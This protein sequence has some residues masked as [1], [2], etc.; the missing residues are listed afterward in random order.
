M[1]YACLLAGDGSF[2]FSFSLF[3]GSTVPAVIKASIM[4]FLNKQVPLGVFPRSCDIFCFLLLCLNPV[5]PS[6]F[7]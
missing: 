3:V 5:A 7:S 4:R 2:V 1:N 6:S